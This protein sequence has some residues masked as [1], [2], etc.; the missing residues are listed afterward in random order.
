MVDQERKEASS[1][2]VQDKG[3]RTLTPV[4]DEPPGRVVNVSK[5]PLADN[6]VQGGDRAA[7]SISLLDLPDE[8]E[9]ANMSREE[10]I[11]VEEH[12]VVQDDQV[13][14]DGAQ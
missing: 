7:T 6:A 11:V 2:Q 9:P 10:L 13:T 12:E 4:R 5:L 1:T 3:Q 8:V 14:I